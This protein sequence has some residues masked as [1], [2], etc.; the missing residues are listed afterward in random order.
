MTDDEFVRAF[1]STE[2]PAEAFPHAGHVRVAWWYLQHEPIL[3][4]LARFRTALQRFAAAK[5]KPDRYHET[6][7]IAFMLLIAERLGGTRDLSWDEFAK[8]YPDLLQWQPSVLAQFYSAEALASPRAKE[9]FVLPEFRGA[10]DDSL[11]VP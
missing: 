1:E 4:A 11:L 7:T 3:T 2:L 5:G 9:T 6:I 8:S 10:R